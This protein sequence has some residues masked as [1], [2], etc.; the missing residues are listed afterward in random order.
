MRSR[1]HNNKKRLGQRQLRKGHRISVRQDRSGSRYWV[2][3]ERLRRKRSLRKRMLLTQRQMR[4][5]VSWLQVEPPVVVVRLVLSSNASPTRWR[6]SITCCLE[7]GLVQQA[8]L[9]ILAGPK[10]ELG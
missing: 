2:E 3:I 6:R 8:G 10:L 4:K 9:R 1:L 5:L 7:R